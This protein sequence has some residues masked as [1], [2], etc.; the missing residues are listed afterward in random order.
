MKDI[1]FLFGAGASFGTGFIIPEKP[2][3]G[4]QLFQLL[5]DLYPKSWGAIPTEIK[6]KFDNENFENGMGELYEKYSQIV[7]QLMREMA[8][9]FI[10]FRPVSDESLYCK[11]I[12]YLKKTHLLSKVLFSTINYDCILEFSL[13]RH[14]VSI[15]YFDEGNEK[16]IP[17]WKLHGSC[18]YFS[19]NVKASGILYTKGVVFEGGIEAF[20]DIGL[21]VE[22]CLVNQALA[23]AMCL[24]MRGKPLQ[25][26]PSV[27]LN[28][29]CNWKKLILTAQ[30][31]FCIGVNPWPDD[32]HVWD[33]IIQ[34]KGSVYFVGDM[35][36]FN[37]RISSCRKGPS[38]FLSDRFLNALELILKEVSK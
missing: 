8:V 2:P 30:K 3:L 33:P 24:Y 35:D 19:K 21:V 6:N 29:Q 17:V 27:I 9:Y 22:N 28:L 26:S 13:L 4:S 34:T 10:Q 18:N 12:G 32:N 31:I 7:P 5:Y 15:S 23:P 20:L 16:D 11:L 14:G 38:D 1:V 36:A 37:E 25:I